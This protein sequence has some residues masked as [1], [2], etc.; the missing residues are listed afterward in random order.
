VALSLDFD[1]T[2]TAL[3]VERTVSRLERRIKSAHP[4]VTRVFI[5]A[6]NFEASRRAAADMAATNMP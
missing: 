6:Q 2:Q 4:E 1:D 3:S 5:E